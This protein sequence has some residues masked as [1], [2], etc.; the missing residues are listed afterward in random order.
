RVTVANL[1]QA[2][3]MFGLDKAPA[4]DGKNQN[5]AM[6]NPGRMTQFAPAL[7]NL[8]KQIPGLANSLD[9]IAPGLGGIARG[10]AGG[11]A[12]LVGVLG[13]QTELEGKK[14]VTLPVRF[15]DGRASVGPIPLGE[16]PALF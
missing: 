8:D 4:R 13:A 2:I 12:A 9:R 15:N 11:V 5:Q 14:A 1:D 6:L 10:N 3:A 7:G 16:V